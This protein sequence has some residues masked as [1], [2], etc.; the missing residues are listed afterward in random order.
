LASMTS[1]F[2]DFMRFF[3]QVARAPRMGA[4]GFGQRN[5]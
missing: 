5:V 1:S 3:A 4:H 2:S